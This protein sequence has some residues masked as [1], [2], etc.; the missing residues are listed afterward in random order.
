MNVSE[1]DVINIII[2]KSKLYLYFLILSLQNGL[3][4]ALYFNLPFLRFQIMAN[5]FNG[6]LHHDLTNID[7]PFMIFYDLGTFFSFTFDNE[8]FFVRGNGSFL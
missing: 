4:G 7:S 3:I 1:V 8:T 5:F 2:N 6:A